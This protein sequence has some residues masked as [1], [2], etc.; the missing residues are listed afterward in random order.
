M[1][2]VAD[3]DSVGIAISSLLITDSDFQLMPPERAV[4]GG[5]ALNN[6]RGMLCLI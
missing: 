1:A 4:E 6:K 2:D 5:L 3:Y